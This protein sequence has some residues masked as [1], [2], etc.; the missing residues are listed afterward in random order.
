MHKL[1]LDSTPTSAPNSQPSDIQSPG[2]TQPDLSN[3]TS[4][5][6]AD[7]ALEPQSATVKPYGA[8]PPENMTKKISLPIVIAGCLVVLVA[9]SA[10]GYGAYQLTTQS[11]SSDPENIENIE[12]VAGSSVKNGDVFGS[13]NEDAFKDSAEG[14]LQAGGINGEGSHQ[15]LREGG[16]SQTVYLTSS[17]TDLDKLVGM[18]VKVWGETFKAQQAGWLMDVGRVQVQ[19]TKP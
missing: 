1:T 19:E 10:T 13:A 4:P 18:K 2:T 7:E 5:P 3:P 16:E 11:G 9:G 6:I 15:L 8:P 17:V 14:V 12:Q